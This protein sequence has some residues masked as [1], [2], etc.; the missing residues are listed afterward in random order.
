MLL[1]EEGEFR[2]R[3]FKESLAAESARPNGDF[4]LDH[5]VAAAEPIHV[6]VQ[7]GLDAASLVVVKLVVP[8]IR[9]AD[10]DRQVDRSQDGDRGKLGSHVE[11]DNGH[12]QV[13]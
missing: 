5:L 13:E 9:G 6:G 4:R 8:N 3:S 11:D 10:G 7:E 12:H 2:L 1:R